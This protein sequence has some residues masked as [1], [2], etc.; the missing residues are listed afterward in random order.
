MKQLSIIPYYWAVG[1]GIY[2]NSEQ[3]ISSASE[4]QALEWKIYITLI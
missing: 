3:N 4:K 2:S 1:H